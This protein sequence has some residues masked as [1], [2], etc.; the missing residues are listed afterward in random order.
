MGFIIYLLEWVMVMRDSG[1]EFYAD[2]IA[3]VLYRFQI[4]SPNYKVLLLSDHEFDMFNVECDIVKSFYYVIT[5]DQAFRSNIYK[6]KYYE[7]VTKEYGEFFFQSDDDAYISAA[8]IHINKVYNTIEPV[9]EAIKILNDYQGTDK[10]VTFL[11]NLLKENAEYDYLVL[12]RVTRHN[13]QL[14]E[15]LD[16]NKIYFDVIHEA[17]HIVE[18]EK[19][20]SWWKIW[21]KKHRS[22]AEMDKITSQLYREWSLKS[23]HWLKL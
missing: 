15:D 23:I 6:N 8:L 10:H 20:R 7:M 11:H 16:D 17:I 14:D 18:H 3:Y 22:A 12:L 5:Q 2:L 9:N 1:V 19:P 21:S 4:N 13:D